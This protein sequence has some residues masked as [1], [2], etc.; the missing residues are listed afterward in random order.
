MR[1]VVAVVLAAVLVAVAGAL[2]PAAPASA[3]VTLD[4]RRLPGSGGYAD[5]L[6]I[7][8]VTQPVVVMNC[9]PLTAGTGFAVR[10]FS[11]VLTARASVSGIALTYYLPGGPALS[12]VHPRLIRPPYTLKKSSAAFYTSSA[13]LEGFYQPIGDVGAGGFLLGAEKLSSPLGSLR[14]VP[15]N[16]LIKP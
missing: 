14:T 11:F 7:G 5:P 9:P 3:A 4:C 1:R 13:G 8:A 6:R 16:V 2:A 10:Y 15:F 12:G